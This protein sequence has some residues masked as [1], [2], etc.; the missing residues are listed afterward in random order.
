MTAAKQSLR[1][2]LCLAALYLLSVC[3]TVFAP[4]RFLARGSSTLFL[5]VLSLALLMFFTEHIID[6]ATRGLLMGIAGLITL[7]MLLR[8]AKYIAFEETETVARHLW[9]CYYLPILLIPLLSLLAA[10]AVARR[11]GWRPPLSR[12]VLMSIS[13]A[14]TAAL[15]LLILTN[16]LHQWAFRFLPGFTHWDSNYIRGPV[17]YAVCLWNLFLL[18]GVLGVLFTRCRLSASRRLIWVPLLP[19]AAG[20]CYLVLYAVGLWPRLNGQLLGEFPESVCFTM[21]GIWL[22]LISIGLIP[23]NQGYDRLFVASNLAAQI[24]DRRYRVIYRSAGAAELSPEAL[25]SEGPIALGENAQVHRRPVAGGYV[26]WQDDLTELNRLSEVLREVGERLAEEA[27]LVR[28]ENTLKEERAQIAA[29][30]RAYDEIAAQVL[31]QSKRIAALCAEAER[32]PERFSEAMNTV[33]LLAVY[34]KRYAN[35][36]LL[37]ADHGTL[38]AGEL[39]LALAE[40]LHA[41]EAL[42]IPT[43]LFFAGKSTLAADA[44]LSAYALFETL[45]EQALP[46]LRGLQITLRAGLLRMVFEGGAPVLPAGSPAFLTVEDSVSYVTLPLGEGGAAI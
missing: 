11:P 32:D 21:A 15:L 43:G 34:C 42:G 38:E 20:L 12:R 30:T 45:L 2:L 9:Y 23:S 25:A 8:G 13:T 5:L 39:R 46:A 37:S 26:Y 14:V 36:S 7:W 27:E 4:D 22:S 10:L 44:A 6:R 16:D 3:I 24:A 18:L 31:P 17:F 1:V 28:L 33:C 29:K 40:S 41:L 19:T 35:L